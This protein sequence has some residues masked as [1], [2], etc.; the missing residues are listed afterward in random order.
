MFQNAIRKMYELSTRG[1]EV[2]GETRSRSLSPGHTP[3][4]P[5]EA[6]RTVQN[7]LRN[8]DN[9]IQQLEHRLRGNERQ[10]EE[11]NSKLGINEEARRRLEKEL[12]DAR[13]ENGEL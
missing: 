10:I 7:A 3:V 12:N 5:Q 9:E 6:V 11:L 4:H 8:R 1:K 2:D 13:R